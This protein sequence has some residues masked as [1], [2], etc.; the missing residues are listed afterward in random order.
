[1]NFKKCEIQIDKRAEFG[2]GFKLWDE[3][4]NS[5]YLNDQQK[6][7]IRAAIEKCVR[8]IKII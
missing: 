5:Y 1:M 2:N 6:E 3:N 7:I 8:K 4:G